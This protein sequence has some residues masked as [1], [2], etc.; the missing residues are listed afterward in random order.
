MVFTPKIIPHLDLK[1]V[2]GEWQK[3]IH[4]PPTLHSRSVTSSLTSSSDEP[5]IFD[6]PGK[7]QEALVLPE[8]NRVVTIVNEDKGFGGKALVYDFETGKLIYTFDCKNNIMTIYRHGNILFVQPDNAW[9]IQAWDLTT[10]KPFEL[11]ENWKRVDQ[12]CFSD[13]FIVHNHFK[14]SID[15]HVSKDAQ[16]PLVLHISDPITLKPLQSLQTGLFNIYDML[17]VNGQL[18]VLG[19][20]DN[21]TVMADFSD[22]SGCLM[23]YDS[24]EK[25]NPDKLKVSFR[26]DYNGG[27]RHVLKNHQGTIFNTAWSPSV[28]TLWNADT[29]NSQLE[30]PNKGGSMTAKLGN[31]AVIIDDNEMA[32]CRQEQDKFNIVKTIEWDKNEP[33]SS[34]EI[35]NFSNGKFSAE[36]YESGIVRIRN[37]DTFGIQM[38]LTPPQNMQEVLYTQFVKDKL[39]VHYNKP[40][41][42]GTLAVL[43]DL[44]TQTP[45]LLIT[46][47]A[48]KGRDYQ[49]QYDTV[50]IVDNHILLRSEDQFMFYKGVI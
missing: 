35:F 17:I 41:T 14:G 7:G 3:Y 16:Q 33:G 29:L 9:Q 25:E 24:P 46:R 28:T 5:F 42:E 4:R 12:I 22:N 40:S 11:S 38:E 31:I 37:L 21:P 10:G 30:K 23:R 44:Q 49:S 26:Y 39:L 36:G 50:H 18:Y 1:E 27:Y 45:S 8:W 20:D 6:L 13:Q 48:L 34:I 15:I 2:Y 43:W 47:A 19:S 32:I